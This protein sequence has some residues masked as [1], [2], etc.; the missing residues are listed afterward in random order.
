MASTD[1][2]DFRA[3]YQWSFL[4]DRRPIGFVRPWPSR[5]RERRLEQRP[6]SVQNPEYAV[7][8]RQVK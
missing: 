7:Q 1:N 6:S 8:L 3:T 5:V 4:Y 2:R